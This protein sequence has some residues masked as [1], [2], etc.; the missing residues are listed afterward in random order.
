MSLWSNGRILSVPKDERLE[1]LGRQWASEKTVF[2]RLLAIQALSEFPSQENQKLI[3]SFLDDTR[4]EKAH[5]VGKWQ[6]GEYSVRKKAAAVLEG[7]DL[8]TP[9]LPMSGPL[10]EY[11]SIRMGRVAS[12]VLLAGCVFAIAALGLRRRLRLSFLPIRLGALALCAAA[13]AILWWRSQSQVDELMF[14][15]GPSHHAIASY[16]GGVQYQVMHDWTASKEMMYGSFDRQLCDDV[17]S[18][19]SQNPASRRSTI[20]FAHAS[21]LGMGPGQTTHRFGLIRIPDWALFSL[22][23][24]PI[25]LSLRGFTGQIRRRRL[26]LCLH[27]GYDLRESPSGACPECGN[28]I[29]PRRPTISPLLLETG[30]EMRIGGQAV[31]VGMK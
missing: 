31:T 5:R 14:S 11:Q 9:P 3:E 23:I 12:V 22:A 1:Q 28:E 4:T 27:C 21:G 15:V 24:I 6:V 13:L 10:L 2:K 18:I 25:A 7:W 8:P 30:D 29:P 26:G 20:G 16:S 17:W 19:D